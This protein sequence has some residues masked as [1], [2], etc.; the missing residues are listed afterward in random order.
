MDGWVCRVNTD[1]CWPFVAI[2]CKRVTA[3]YVFKLMFV[4]FFYT[5][6]DLKRESTGTVHCYKARC[7]T[8]CTASLEMLVCSS[9][10][11]LCYTSC[12]ASA[13]L[14]STYPQTPACANRELSSGPDMVEICFVKWYQ[15]NDL[16][17]A[18]ALSL[19]RLY[20]SSTGPG[21]V[22]PGRPLSPAS[23]HCFWEFTHNHTLP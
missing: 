6:V 19:R 5:Y 2:A 9:H 16:L 12:N 8:R 14:C 22:G 21:A 4:Y 23:I 7:R 15:F 13:P 3:M 11:V 18:V 20:S 10:R 17:G 1:T